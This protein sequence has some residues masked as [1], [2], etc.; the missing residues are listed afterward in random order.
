[1]ELFRLIRLLTWEASDKSGVMD[2][3]LAPRAVADKP[4]KKLLDQVRDVMRSKQ[5]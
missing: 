4:K 3:I 2:G 1:M 5:D